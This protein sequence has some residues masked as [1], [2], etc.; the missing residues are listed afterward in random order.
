MYTIIT[1][2]KKVV[3][4]DKTVNPIWHPGESN[5][6]HFFATHDVTGIQHFG[7]GLFPINVDKKFPIL[8]I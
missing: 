4:I 1:A 6:W 5:N 8:S 2:G 3:I 7:N